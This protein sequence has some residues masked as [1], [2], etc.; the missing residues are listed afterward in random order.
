[1]IFG[2]SWERKWREAG[3]SN[4]W[5]ALFIRLGW[6][7]GVILNI[8][9]GQQELV[10]VFVCCLCVGCVCLEILRVCVVCV[11]YVLCVMCWGVCY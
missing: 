9:K 4:L 1:M 10:S 6:L 11:S 3:W 8:M 2:E 5:Q 7:T